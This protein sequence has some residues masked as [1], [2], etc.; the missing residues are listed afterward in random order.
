MGLRRAASS[1]Q[2]AGILPRS[3]ASIYRGICSLDAIPS[4]PPLLGSDESEPSEE[5]ATH[6]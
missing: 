5:R 2:R 6:F 3:T 4:S 1:V